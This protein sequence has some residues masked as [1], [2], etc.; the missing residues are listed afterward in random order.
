V[1]VVRNVVRLLTCSNFLI[2]I[3]GLRLRL[4]MGHRSSVEL[5][6]VPVV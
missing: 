6:T 5:Y 1:N 3:Y 4:K 2:G